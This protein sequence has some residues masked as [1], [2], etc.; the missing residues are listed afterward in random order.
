MKCL[1]CGQENRN[2]IKR[3]VNCSTPL[4]WTPDS[5]SD[6]HVVIKVS[7]LAIAAIVLASCG[8]LFIFF[9][10]LAPYARTQSP[11][12]SIRGLFFLLSLIMFI[13]AFICGFIGLIGIE[14]SGGKK[15]GISFAI[16]A[17]VASVLGCIL[18]VGV[19]FLTRTRSVAFVM[20]CGTNLSGL[21]KA[22]LIYANDYDDE[23]PRAGGKG[24]TWGQSVNYAAA[25]RHQ[26]YGL[27][28]QGTG[29]SATI[30]SS[31]YLLV[32]YAEVTPKSFI[33]QSRSKD[34]TGDKGV[35]EFKPSGNI[36]LIS[37]WDFGPEPWKHNSYAYHMPYGP[38]ALT[39]S[40]NPAMAVAADRN[41]WIPSLGW[42]VKNFNSFSPDGGKNFTKIGNAPCHRDEGQNVL[43]LDSHV[44]FEDKSF[45]G[46][47]Q[48]N[49][50]TSWNG[51]DIRK[52]T[53]P[54]VGSQPVDKLDS[55]L[56]ND[57]PLQKP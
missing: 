7:R 28:S 31:L 6:E 26:A 14:I 24:S 13:L 18:P 40:S 1:K 8:L 23:F 32:K 42:G 29:G 46:I 17:I 2:D 34:G 48:D 50:Y 38:N 30:S 15:T 20:V 43:F 47:N 36:D 49:I 22:M 4:L 45:C 44:N 52:G 57:P 37:L 56:V 3:C 19:L 41:P 53:P 33:C 54:K 35:S 5:D 25:T 16:G 9:G 55:L 10:F 21:G 39:T 12:S 11:I 51:S 27:N